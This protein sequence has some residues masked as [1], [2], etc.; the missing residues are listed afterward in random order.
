M[1]MKP[2]SSKSGGMIAKASKGMGATS[3]SAFNKKGN[4]SNSPMRHVMNKLKR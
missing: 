4:H 1:K 2:V 3:T